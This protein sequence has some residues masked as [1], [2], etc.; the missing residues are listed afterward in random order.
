VPPEVWLALY[1][2]ATLFQLWVYVRNRRHNVSPF[3]D[4]DSP[5]LRGMAMSV[6]AAPIYATALISTVFR[7]PARFV[8]TAK[9]AARNRDSLRVFSRHLAWAALL[10]VA[11]SV[12]I[13]AGY[14]NVDVLMWPAL[15]LLISVAPLALSWLDQP[16][17]A[18]EVEQQP[19]L[20]AAA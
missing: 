2:D 3:E 14:A 19:I 9:D 5:G 11:I 18:A 1:V 10:V 16:A 17:P 4:E 6:L 13:A 20:E 7:R 15:A 8:V 12:A